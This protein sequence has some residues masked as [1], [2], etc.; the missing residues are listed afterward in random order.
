MS[1]Q[2]QLLSTSPYLGPDYGNQLVDDFGTIPASSPD[3]IRAA[4]VTVA[5]RSLGVE[6]ARELLAMLG[7]GES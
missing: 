7:L 2:T 6:D 4:R 1:R 3:E 5:A